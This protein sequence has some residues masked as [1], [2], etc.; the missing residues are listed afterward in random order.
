MS[1]AGAVFLALR[2]R[3]ER[4]IVA[5]LRDRAA[6]SPATAAR[7]PEP[8]GFGRGAMRALVRGRAVI[9]AGAGAYYLD[10]TAYEAMRST[11]RLRIG[12]LILAVLAVTVALFV[13]KGA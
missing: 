10:A 5:A 13:W 4:Q 9:E 2:L 7:L 11:R 8:S 1:A 3:K 12:G 6:T